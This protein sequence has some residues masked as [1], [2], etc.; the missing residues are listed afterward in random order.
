MKVKTGFKIGDSV[1]YKTHNGKNVA[2]RIVKV[3]DVKNGD[4][5]EQYVI[6]ITTDRN[7]TYRKGQTFTTSGNWLIKR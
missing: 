5:T 1:F 7:A 3:N 4:Y 2:G 6:A